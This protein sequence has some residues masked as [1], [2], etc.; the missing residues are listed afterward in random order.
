MLLLNIPLARGRLVLSRD[1]KHEDSS[2]G[3]CCSQNKPQGP[4]ICQHS[5]HCT[6]PMLWRCTL[7]KVKGS[8]P[9]KRDFS[10]CSQSPSSAGTAKQLPCCTVEVACWCCRARMLLAEHFL[11]SAA[12]STSLCLP[13]GCWLQH[14]ALPAQSSPPH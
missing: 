12:L 14:F 6:L 4:Q 3:R 13:D 1:K 2:G 11:G 5:P 9:R 7:C 10:S 8:W